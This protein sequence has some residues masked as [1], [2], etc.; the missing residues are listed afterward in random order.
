MH[1]M[2][3]QVDMR[4]FG[5]LR[6]VCRSRSSPSS[7]GYLAIIG[8]PA[9]RPGFFS[10]DPIIEAAFDA[11][12]APAGCFGRVALLGAGI[13]AFYMT[14]MM[15][16]TFFGRAPW[17][18]D[19]HPHESPPVMTVPMVVLAVGSVVLGRAARPTVA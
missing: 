9:V 10:K 14:R 8:V 15:I 18:E 13:T 1:G 6:S 7:C 12:A 5:G 11:R 2:D 17:T 3:D 4:R 16:M 19:A